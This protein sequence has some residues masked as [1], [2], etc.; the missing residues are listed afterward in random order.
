MNDDR[1]MNLSQHAAR[2]GYNREQLARFKP[3]LIGGKIRPSELDRHIYDYR[4]ALMEQSIATADLAAIAAPEP[5]ADHRW[6][7][8]EGKFHKA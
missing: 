7:A 3:L 4:K 6:R 1:A 2:T 5:A 8:I